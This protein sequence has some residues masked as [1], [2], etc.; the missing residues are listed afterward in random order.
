MS[1]PERPPSARRI[2][3]ER[4]RFMRLLGMEL[5]AAEGGYGEARL[6]I[7]EDHLNIYG[8]VHGGVILTLA[9]E[10]FGAAVTSLGRCLGI[11]WSTNIIRAPVAGDRLLATARAA[12]AGSR[13]VVCEVRVT[14]Q[15]DKPIAVGTATALVLEGTRDDM[16]PYHDR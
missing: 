12:H 13:T 2:F 11:Q 9:D 10:A 16:Y 15:D 7:T 3:A 1:E 4:D 14:N 8:S 5:V 6:E